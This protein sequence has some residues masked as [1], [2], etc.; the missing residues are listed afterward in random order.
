MFLNIN[1][2]FLQFLEVG[3]ELGNNYPDVIAPQ[4]VATYGGLCALATFD[5]TELKACLV[6][7]YCESCFYFS[8]ICLLQCK[9][10]ILQNKVIDNINFR[11][12]LE[13]V[14]EI[15]ELINDFYSR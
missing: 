1:F 8:I 7:S 2:E 13:L 15:R 3:P 11:N 10:Q 6:H 12:F 5:R 14:P 9:S 4:D